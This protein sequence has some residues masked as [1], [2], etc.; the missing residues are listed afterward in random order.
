VIKYAKKAECAASGLDVERVDHISRALARVA[1]DAQ[2]LGL[3]IFGGERG[4]L[5]V[6]SGSIV[7]SVIDDGSWGREET[8]G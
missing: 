1:R 4:A 7:V 5:W 8:H 2:R 3:S 6:R